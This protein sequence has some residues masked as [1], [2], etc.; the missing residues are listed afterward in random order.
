MLD[1]SD[2]STLNKKGVD[3]F[4][5][6]KQAVLPVTHDDSVMI[7][8]ENSLERF[9]MKQSM[10]LKARKI[11]AINKKNVSVIMSKIKSSDEIIETKIDLERYL[12]GYK[13]IR[14]EKIN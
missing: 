9:H 3:S 11:E 7:I 6:I 13:L 2:I 1:L 4:L 5:A 10:I 8:E 14:F 12:D